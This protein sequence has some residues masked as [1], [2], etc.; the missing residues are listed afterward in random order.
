MRSLGD[1]EDTGLPEPE[2]AL[3]GF[4]FLFPFLFVAFLL[5]RRV[6]DNRTIL[7]YGADPPLARLKGSAVLRFLDA[8]TVGHAATLVTDEVPRSI[9]TFVAPRHATV[10]TVDAWPTSTPCGMS[11]RVARWPNAP[12]P[13]PARGARGNGIRANPQFM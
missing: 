2:R 5:L 10:T 7:A 12:S 6:A 3:R 13:A 11:I 8:A 1:P 9:G 4:G